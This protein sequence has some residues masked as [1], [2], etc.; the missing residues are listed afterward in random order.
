MPQQ[1][2]LL[3][4]SGS[5][6]SLHLPQSQGPARPLPPLLPPSTQYPPLALALS[7]T[8]FDSVGR[9]VHTPAVTG[10]MPYQ[11]LAPWNPL[12]VLVLVLSGPAKATVGGTS[13]P[14]LSIPEMYLAPTRPPK[15]RSRNPKVPQRYVP[16]T[17]SPVIRTRPTLFQAL[18]WPGP[19][20]SHAC[21]QGSL[22]FLFFIPLVPWP[23]L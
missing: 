7:F 23:M 2:L 22:L 12:R 1:L 4:K 16:S 6:A 11:V 9:P 20:R 8:L 3:W 15:Y 5:A 13:T 17:T 18:L 19:V 21:L 10:T 14:F